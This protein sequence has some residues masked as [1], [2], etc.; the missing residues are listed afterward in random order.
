MQSKNLYFP[1]PQIP[2]NLSSLF[3]KKGRLHPIGIFPPFLPVADHRSNQAT[4]S[5]I[6]SVLFRDIQ[7]TNYHI[8]V[9]DD[10]DNIVPRLPSR[11]GYSHTG[12]HF[13]LSVQH[14]ALHII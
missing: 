9:F 12:R 11:N 7:F 2:Q 3:T 1:F 4:L 14:P 8:P 6:S 13:F 5:E 10:P